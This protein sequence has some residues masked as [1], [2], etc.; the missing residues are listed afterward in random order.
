MFLKCTPNFSL[1]E[2]K[3]N[4][5]KMA[6]EY[7][8]ARQSSLSRLHHHT[9]DSSGRSARRRDLYL[10]T[11]NTHKIETSVP[12]AGFEPAIPASE[13][14]QTQALDRAVTGIGT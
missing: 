4:K 8:W 14:L 11:H 2:E 3:R 9:Q 6:E 10:T 12:P 7:C 5:T 1:R 13:R